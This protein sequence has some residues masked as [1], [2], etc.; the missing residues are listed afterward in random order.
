MSPDHQQNNL[1]SWRRIEVFVERARVKAPAARFLRESVALGLDQYFR[2]DQ[3]MNALTFS[4]VPDGRYLP[5]EP[6][7]IVNFLGEEGVRLVYRARNFSTLEYTLTFDAAFPTFRR[8]LNQL[9]TDTMP[10]PIPEALR[11]F[12]APVLTPTRQ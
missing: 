8:F 11:G 12:F 6:R 9:W 3:S 4:T 5:N 1:A 2:A 10:E 7:V